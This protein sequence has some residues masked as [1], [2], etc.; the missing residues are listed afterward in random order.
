MITYLYKQILF[1]AYFT[2]ILEMLYNLYNLC[3]N[4]TYKYS[5]FALNYIQIIDIFGISYIR[6]RACR[7]MLYFGVTCRS[8]LYFKKYSQTSCQF[9]LASANMN[10]YIV[11]TWKYGFYYILLRLPLLSWPNP[12]VNNVFGF[13]VRILCIRYVQFC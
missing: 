6:S 4:F 13:L 10:K 3:T 5:C 7:S 11:F 12:S 2:L 1:L 9:M 8:M